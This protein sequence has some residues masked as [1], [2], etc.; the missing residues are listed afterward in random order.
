MI[1]EKTAP[2]TPPDHTITVY[3]T[4]FDPETT[5]TS[6]LE[7]MEDRTVEFVLDSSRTASTTIT[8]KL[9]GEES[10]GLFGPRSGSFTL[11]RESPSRAFTTQLHREEVAYELEALAVDPQG[12][13]EGHI[14]IVKGA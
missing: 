4:K 1:H 2:L 9:N 14:K 12:P 8:I 11:T 10:D 3:P 13:I 7:V 5:A 6:P